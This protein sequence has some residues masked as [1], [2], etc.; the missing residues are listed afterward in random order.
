MARK[1]NTNFVKL[2]I[3]SRKQYIQMAHSKR[4]QSQPAS[5]TLR[6]IAGIIEQNQQINAIGIE[7]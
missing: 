7:I 6:N 4:G 3:I 1:Y 2:L 5:A